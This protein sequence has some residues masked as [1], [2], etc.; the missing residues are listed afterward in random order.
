MTDHDSSYQSSA[1]FDISVE[2]FISTSLNIFLK[3][4]SSRTNTV[5]IKFFPEIEFFC[6]ETAY[7]TSVRLKKLC[8]SQC[9]DLAL[10]LVKAFMKCYRLSQSENFNLNATETQ[11][12]FIFDIYVALLYKFKENDSLLDMVSDITNWK[13]INKLHCLIHSSKAW[14]RKKDW[15]S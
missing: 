10:N 11:V 7:L 2:K 15:I 13:S 1:Y 3:G 9:E 4:L 8:E 5:W 6:V 12:W 14:A